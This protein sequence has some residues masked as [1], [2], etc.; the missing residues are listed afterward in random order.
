MKILLL[1][2]LFFWFIFGCTPAKNHTSFSDNFDDGDFTNNPQWDFYPGGTGCH[3]TGSANVING[4]FHVLKDNAIGCGTGTQIEHSLNIV[5]ANNTKITFDINPVFSDV[6][7]G[8]GWTNEEYPAFVNLRLW[9]ANNDSID[10]R[11]CYNYRGGVSHLSTD[12]K[13]N[14]IVIPNV[15]KNVWQRNQ[16]FK[17][18]DYVSDATR[19]SKIF[20]GGNGWDYEGY[21]DNIRIEN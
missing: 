5:V 8:A 19:I 9:K 6:G 21:F 11:F 2:L 4:Q 18:R 7:D 16:M 12:G 20:I 1:C 3:I 10:I 13:T 15:Q 14:F 17:V